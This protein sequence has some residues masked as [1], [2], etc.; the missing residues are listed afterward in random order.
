MSIEEKLVSYVN[1]VT[2]SDL[3]P[4]VILAGK[5]S[6]TDVL[7]VSIAGSD[8][9]VVKKLAT[10]VKQWGGK[11][12]STIFF[13]DAMVPAHHAVL[14]NSTMA[15]ALDF[16]EYHM[17]LGVHP[18]PTMVPVALATAELCGKVTGKEF[19]TAV[20][21]G[22]EV[23]CRMRLVPDYCAG[24]SGWAAEIYGGFGAAVTAGK[25]M[26][27]SSEEMT[28]ALGLAYS[29]AAGN[30]QCLQDGGGGSAIALQQGFSA[31]AGLSSAILA[32][33]GMAGAKNFL[34]GRAGLYPVYYRDIPYDINRLLN[35]FGETYEIL[36][37]AA[38]PYPTCGFTCC[39]IGN[40]IEIMCQNDLSR[41]DV[42]KVVLRIN[43]AM[44]NNT[45]QP[46]ELKYRP[47][48]MADAIFSLP[49]TVGSAIFQGDVFLED[50]TPEAIKDAR[51][52][53]EVDKVEIVLDQDIE[54]EASKLNLRLY[55][56]VAEIKTKN[57][58]SF[59]QKMLYAKG[60]PQKP[61]TL[62]DCAEKARR[63]ARFAVKEFSENKVSQLVEMIK[64]LEQLEDIRS[65]IKFL[66]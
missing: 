16:D 37:L 32:Q 60:S 49:Y 30:T 6:I 24:F 4:E 43:Q 65:L 13:Y 59:S 25:L 41:E 18:I 22:S 5:K 20:V 27:F 63:C 21:I 3:P 50:F 8:A 52:L 17:T 29:Q 66:R 10:L 64:D 35:G 44:Y 34:E 51:R 46:R 36:N 23:M 55:L 14:V 19:I 38:K 42:D 56:H 58:K 62:E 31:R 12:E 2:Y 15:R 53:S 9:L 1:S 39:P 33:R 40:V 54:E 28:N 57:G 26:R 45:C 48:I 61:M 7:G 47:K 11:P